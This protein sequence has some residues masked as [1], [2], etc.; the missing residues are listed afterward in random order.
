MSVTTRNTIASPVGGRSSGAALRDLARG[1]GGLLLGAGLI[2]VIGLFAQF[3]LPD[4]ARGILGRLPW[5]ET[6]AVTLYYPDRD[7]DALVP[8]TRVVGEEPGVGLALAELAAGPVDIEKLAP[9]LGVAVP[10]VRV[11]A[12]TALVEY[13][14]GSVPGTLELAA[15]E[16]TLLE[17]PAI[18]EVRIASGDLVLDGDVAAAGLN[19][20]YADNAYLLPVAAPA[21]TTDLG[22]IVDLYLQGFGRRDGLVGLPADVELVDFRL[23]Q[24][25][26]LLVVDLTYTDSLREFALANE[27]VMRRVLEGLI[28]TLTQFASVEAVLLSFEGHTRLGQGG[29]SDL[30]RAP[31]VAPRAIN[32]EVKVL[33][34]GRTIDGSSN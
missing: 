16:R 14:T 4:G 1:R 26:G 31:Q 32:D 2:V 15:L 25:R 22:E 33:S 23:D 19:L 12:T 9:A 18:N 5:L 30:L 11:E 13:P 6:N 7:G 29:C 27:T 20:Y 28:A 17:L 21:E 34:L 3:A 8:V 24:D 10:T